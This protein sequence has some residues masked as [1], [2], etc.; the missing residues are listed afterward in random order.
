MRSED[1]GVKWGFCLKQTGLAG[2]LFTCYLGVRVAAD[3]AI[4]G[5]SYNEN[6]SDCPEYCHD[7]NEA[8]LLKLLILGSKLTTLS[9]G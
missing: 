8:R 7:E 2:P 3:R 5:H 1:D 9:C 6:L 4:A